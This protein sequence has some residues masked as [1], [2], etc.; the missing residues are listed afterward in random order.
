MIQSQ[1]PGSSNANCVR[2]SEPW[3]IIMGILRHGISAS[4]HLLPIP[5]PLLVQAGTVVFAQLPPLVSPA[6]SA[7]ILAQ[8][9][10]W[11]ILVGVR[12]GEVA[13]RTGT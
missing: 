12:G 4:L 8:L 10:A 11:R 3:G 5:L 13:A 9:L 2:D 6:C 7:R 1:I